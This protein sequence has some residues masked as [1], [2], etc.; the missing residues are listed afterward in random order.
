MGCGD[1]TNQGGNERLSGL[2]NLTDSCVA[3]WLSGELIKSIR[4]EAYPNILL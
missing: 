4:R 3:L 1:M 2:P